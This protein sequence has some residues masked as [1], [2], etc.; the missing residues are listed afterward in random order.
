MILE[1]TVLG[2]SLNLEKSLISSMI[3]NDLIPR[4]PLAPLKKQ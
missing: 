1:A 3:Q 4:P 2:K